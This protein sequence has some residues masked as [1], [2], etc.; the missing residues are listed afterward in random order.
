MVRYSR[1]NC[2]MIPC[3]FYDDEKDTMR[4]WKKTLDKV[5]VAFYNAEANKATG[6]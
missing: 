3:F 5:L 1:D 4:C 6:R 2:T